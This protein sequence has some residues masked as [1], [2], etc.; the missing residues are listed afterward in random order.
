M[1]D[2]DIFA[3]GGTVRYDEAIAALRPVPAVR[4]AARRPRARRRAGATVDLA[5]GERAVANLTVRIDADAT[6]GIAAIIDG[7]PDAPANVL[8]DGEPV[9]ITTSRASPERGGRMSVD[10]QRAAVARSSSSSRRSC[11]SSS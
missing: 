4:L 10:R 3:G 7:L 11:C 6:D 1:I 8:A 5:A 2:A 9:A